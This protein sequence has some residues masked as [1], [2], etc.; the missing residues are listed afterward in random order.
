MTAD[1]LWQAVLLSIRTVNRRDIFPADEKTGGEQ[2]ARYVL[3]ITE[4]AKLKKITSETLRHYDRIGL[5]KPDHIVVPQNKVPVS[6]TK[7]ANYNSILT[8]T[9]LPLCRK[10]R[11][12]FFLVHFID[13]RY[14]YLCNP[15]K[16][17]ERTTPTTARSFSHP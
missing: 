17:R 6:C 7:T 14:S 15:R 2:M 4:L 13:F 10:K 1:R 11:R 5:L 16:K 8:N 12:S 3:S 9:S